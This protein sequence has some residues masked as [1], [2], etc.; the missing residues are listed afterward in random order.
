MEGNIAG[1]GLRNV[2]YP[3]EDFVYIVLSSTL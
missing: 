2:T 3:G 1:H